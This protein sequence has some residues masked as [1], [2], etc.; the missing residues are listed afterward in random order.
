M[1]STGGEVSPPLAISTKSS[2]AIKDLAAICLV[3]IST[4]DASSSFQGVT[5]PRARRIAELRNLSPWLYISTFEVRAGNGNGSA[6]LF[7]TNIELV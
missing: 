3:V 6:I 7:H 1:K 2:S 4:V 5:V